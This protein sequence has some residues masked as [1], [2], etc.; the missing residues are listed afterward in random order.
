[1]VGFSLYIA[2]SFRTRRAIHTSICVRDNGRRTV[3]TGQSALVW[4]WLCACI[5]TRRGTGMCGLTSSYCTSPEIREVD[6]GRMEVQTVL[7]PELPLLRTL[8]FIP[9]PPIESDDE[10]CED[11]KNLGKVL[12]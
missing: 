10:S 12:I 11:G 3:Q 9:S 7:K 5:L 2:N 6:D 4:Q 8:A 1:M